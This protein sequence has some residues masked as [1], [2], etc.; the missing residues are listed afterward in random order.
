MRFGAADRDP[1]AERHVRLH[2]GLMTPRDS[3]VKAGAVAEKTS[4]TGRT[5]W[6]K[7]AGLVLLLVGFVMLG[8]LFTGEFEGWEIISF[9]VI[10]WAIYLLFFESTT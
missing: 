4:N 2:L 5:L 1:G 9:L 10:S 6:M 3:D 7:G 8:S